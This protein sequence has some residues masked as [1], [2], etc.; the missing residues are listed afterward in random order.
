MSKD[1]KILGVTIGNKILLDSEFADNKTLWHENKHVFDN[2]GII[3]KEDDSA[4][5]KEFNKLRK[6]DKLQ[7]DLSTHEDPIQR[8]KENRANTFAQ[9]MTFREDYRNTSFG[10]MIQKVMN[11]FDQLYL[12]GRR[13][14]TGNQEFQTTSGLAREVESG[15][16]YE[17]TADDL[18]KKTELEV[19][20]NMNI[21]FP[22]VELKKLKVEVTAIREETGEKVKIQEDAGT[23]L[24]AAKEDMAKYQKLL[25]C[26]TG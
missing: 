15:K 13:V 3:T 6:A 12:M 7:F 9:I 25:D 11:F 21:K 18:T 16:L 8:A 5:N 17:R 1:G 14:I 10:K 4:I 22:L 24:E 2:L 23:A 26:L 20:R 19:Q